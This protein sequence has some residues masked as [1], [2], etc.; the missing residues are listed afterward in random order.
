M[1]KKKAA[2]RLQFAIR[3]T[4]VLVEEIRLEAG[5]SDGPPLIRV[6]AMA[7]IHNPYAGK[8]V[9]DIEP[10]IEFGAEIGTLLVQKL[11]AQFGD[12]PQRVE[13]YG[14]GAIVGTRGEIE[15]GYA[16]ITRPFA[17]RVRKALGDATAWMA[18]NVK[19]GA[20]GATL[21]V[22]LAFKNALYVRSHYDTVQAAMPD[23]PLPDEVVVI[24]V[25][26]GRGRLHARIGGLRKQDVKRGRDV[27]VDKK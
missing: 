10:L 4:A 12:D 8:P 5:R 25:G 24:L 20:L 15:H 17:T 7:A 9:A 21:D 27:Y 3:K 23:A 13:S 18:A 14:K 26:A 1:A 11:L 6:A 2:P 22:P 19:R 16:T